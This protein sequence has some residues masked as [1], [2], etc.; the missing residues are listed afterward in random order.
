MKTAALPSTSISAHVA[1]DEAHGAAPLDRVPS[2]R[3]D[4]E[5]LRLTPRQ[6]EVL[7]LLCE[8]LPNKLICRRLSISA[9]TVKAHISGILREL[10]V[11][12]RL[13]AVVAARRSGLLGDFSS[14][15]AG[16]GSGGGKPGARAPT[17]T[18][19]AVDFGQRAP[20]RPAL[21]SQR[22]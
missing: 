13:Q 17:A 5:T 18:V 22:T 8:G 21:V 2:S 15:S 19:T 6:L 9:G 4:G 7:G 3:A 10:G 14:A 12:S 11:G 16:P 1:A 20:Y